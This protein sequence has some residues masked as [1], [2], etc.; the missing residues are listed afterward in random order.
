MYTIHYKLQKEWKRFLKELK[1]WQDIV[2]RKI[3]IF[4]RL[5]FS[6]TCLFFLFLNPVC[7]QLPFL[8]PPC[9]FKHLY[10]LISNGQFIY[11]YASW[12]KN[13][14]ASDISANIPFCTA[15]THVSFTKCSYVLVETCS[16][17]S[18]VFWFIL[19]IIPKLVLPLFRLQWMWVWVPNV[20]LQ[21]L[22]FIHGLSHYNKHIQVHDRFPT[23]GT[24]SYN[25]LL[26][27]KH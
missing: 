18:Y 12:G 1:E 20:T 15:V 10:M 25:Q 19:V 2:K 27:T 6:S 21:S 4:T 13:Q 3:V 24:F 17:L 8:M 16:V 26:F 11:T 23:C 22:T 7:C 14:R 9:L 5:C